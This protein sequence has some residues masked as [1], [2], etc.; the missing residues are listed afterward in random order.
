[1]VRQG[2]TIGVMSM[3]TPG[4][5]IRVKLGDV[6]ELP[7]PDGP[8]A[9]LHYVKYHRDPPV[10]GELIRVLDGIFE[11]RPENIKEIVEKPE[12]YVTFFPLGTCGARGWV[13]RVGNE[14]IPV[15]FDQW[16]LFKLFNQN[17]ETGER[18]WWLSD[19]KKSWRVGT[20]SP[21]HY[22]P[23][24]KEIPNLKMLEDCIV[25]GWHPSHEV[26]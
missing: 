26:R 4:K 20:L 17:V 21:E 25:S 22:D 2:R 3:T 10:F 15:R 8:L 19:M 16:P 6:L 18:D 9:Y 12:R 7:L 1:M 5:R 13:T 23:P 24:L 14:P 11:K